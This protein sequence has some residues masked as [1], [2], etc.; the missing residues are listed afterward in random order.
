MKNQIF[1]FS[2]MS[3]V[4]GACT[5]D[6]KNTVWSAGGPSAKE[7]W[8]IFTGEGYRYGS[9]IIINANSSINAWFAAPGDFHNGEG[10]MM[11]KASGNTMYQLG[12]S[13]FAKSFELQQEC[14]S[15]GIYCPNWSSSTKSMTLTLYKW[16]T[17]YT[18]TLA[19]T[20]VNLSL[21]H[22]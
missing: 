12:S 19:S 14:V 18:T 2:L 4:L 22:I 5:D 9:S 11:Y 21:I 20:P 8:D 1:S 10:D 17:D 13:V 7:G 6:E 3:L 16:D 15:I